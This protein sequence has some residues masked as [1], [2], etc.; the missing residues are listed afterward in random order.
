MF[1][2]LESIDEVIFTMEGQVDV[3]Y[4]INRQVWF[5][6]RTFL[7]SKYF[8]NIFGGFECSYDRRSQVIK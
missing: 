3:G 2:E 5:K 8:Q 6:I 7:R 4:E 1:K